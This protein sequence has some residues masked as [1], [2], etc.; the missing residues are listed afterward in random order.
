MLKGGP[1][2]ARCTLGPR[3]EPEAASG[4]SVHVLRF[5]IGLKQLQGLAHAP[6]LR[7]L[8]T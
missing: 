4:L 8:R 3:D 7:S 1:F 2:G 6:S 5:R